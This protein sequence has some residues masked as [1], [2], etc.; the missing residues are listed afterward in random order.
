ML[1]NCLYV[2]ESDLKLSEY[3]LKEKQTLVFKQCDK[4]QI[5]SLFQNT[6]H[7]LNTWESQGC[8]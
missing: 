8:E 4:L 2:R 7:I 6:A 5:Q 1:D 3:D